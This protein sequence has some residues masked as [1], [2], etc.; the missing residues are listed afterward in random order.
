MGEI[1]GATGFEHL[2]Q[3]QFCGILHL[4]SQ[5]QRNLSVDCS[6]GAYNFLFQSQN[7]HIKQKSIFFILRGNHLLVYFLFHFQVQIS[8]I[9]YSSSFR[10][11]ILLEV[12]KELFS[13][14]FLFCFVLCLSA[15]VH[16]QWVT[17]RKANTQHYNDID[18]IKN[19]HNKTCVHCLAL[20]LTRNKMFDY[21]TLLWTR[22][23]SNG[24]GYICY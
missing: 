16:E 17:H 2:Q 11:C 8:N 13:S 5:G 3:T 20:N 15:S 7:T 21:H 9:F 10:L 14:L 4:Y 6:T 19:K 24:L 23:M 12:K 1:K 18:I 22:P